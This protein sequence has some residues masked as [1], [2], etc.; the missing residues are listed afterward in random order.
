MR[1]G[2]LDLRAGLKALQLDLND[3]QV[4]QLLDYLDLIAKWTKVYNLTAVRDPAEMMT[5]HLLDSLAAIA[6][7]LRHL[8]QAGLEQGASLLD[9]GSGAGLP[10]VVIAVCCPA[11][12]VTCVDTVAKKAAFIKQAALA[13]K[14]PKLTGLHAR[15]ETIA[16]PF[17]VIC[18]RAFA[19]LLDFTQWS[20]G[21]LAPHGVWMAM[22]GKH[23][24]DEIAALP[25]T[26]EV[27]HVEQLAVP[28]LAAER[29]L[30]WL[31]PKAAV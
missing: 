26:V 28:G 6:P 31:R 10:G 18:S 7:L 19:S 21:A 8:Q 29:C 22:K 23:P 3:H 15:V 25:A 30:L 14:L 11:V 9:V 5:H 16:Q 13:L 4:G 24:G 27:F 2:E 20:A 17:D 1:S 12:A